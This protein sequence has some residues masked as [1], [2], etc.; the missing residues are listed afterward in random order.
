LDSIKQQEIK[1]RYE[2]FSQR[3]IYCNCQP[4][5]PTDYSEGQGAIK[6]Y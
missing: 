6:E 3:L 4:N 2:P 1:Q 5:S